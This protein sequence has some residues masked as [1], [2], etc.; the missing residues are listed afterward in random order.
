MRADPRCST[1][2]A[3]NAPRRALSPRVE[4]RTGSDALDTNVTEG[5]GGGRAGGTDGLLR[6]PWCLRRRGLSGS[7]RG[8]SPPSPGDVVLV[9]TMTKVGRNLGKGPD[10]NRSSPVRPGPMGRRPLRISVRKRHTCQLSLPG[11]SGDREAP[12]G[13]ETGKAKGFSWLCRREH[14]QRSGSGRR[15]TVDCH[16]GLVIFCF[17]PDPQDSP[18]ASSTPG[19]GTRG[20]HGVPWLGPRPLRPLTSDWLCQGDFLA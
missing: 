11:Q 7:Q 3:G 2:R 16:A 12:A 1:G 5:P 15:E 4:G 19:A 14:S 6:D 20:P 10:G 17:S 8:R 18:G 13:A 9:G